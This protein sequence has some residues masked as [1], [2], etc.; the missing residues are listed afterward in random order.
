M[1]AQQVILSQVP[2]LEHVVCNLAPQR[3]RLQAV[4]VLAVVV[5]AEPCTL[6]P[7][8]D[9]QAER[10]LR[11]RARSEPVLKVPDDAVDRVPVEAQVAVVVSDGVETR[12]DAVLRKLWRC[13]P[14]VPRRREFE[15]ERVRE[16]PVCPTQR[17]C[18]LCSQRIPCALLR[19]D[20]T[21]NLGIVFEQRLR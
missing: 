4:S 5:V 10:R 18:V 9:G 11:G 21:S 8:A 19:L 7:H 20:V 6:G 1:L 12:Q 14:D 13:V 16:R 2:E 3:Q 15:G 17:R